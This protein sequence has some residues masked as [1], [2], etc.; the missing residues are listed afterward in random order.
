MTATLPEGNTAQGVFV[1]GLGRNRHPRMPPRLGGERMSRVPPGGQ[2]PRPPVWEGEGKTHNFFPHKV[3]PIQIA[4]AHGLVLGDVSLVKD[5]RIPRLWRAQVSTTHPALERAFVEGFLP[6][7]IDGR[8][9]K[10]PV[11][12]GATPYKWNIYAWISAEIAE[13]LAVKGPRATLLYAESKDLLAA[14]TAGLFDSDGGLSLAIVRRK[15]MNYR[16][17]FEPR[18]AIYNADK[19]LLEA[20]RRSWLKYGIRL[21]LGKDR[22]P[23]L[24]RPWKGKLVV[25]ELATASYPMIVR[26]LL[27]ILPYMKHWEKITKAKITIKHIVSTIPW[28]PQPIASLR[29][30]IDSLIRLQVHEYIKQAEQAYKDKKAYIITRNGVIEKKVKKPKRKEDPSPSLYLIL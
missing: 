18:V 8:I 4:Y 11:R 3:H 26:F 14:F 20:L 5:R 1:G 24:K 9:R 27:T 2:S 16:P 12:G 13:I 17:R 22:S 30:K 25:Y 15:R 7:S 10:Y 23:Q 6:L 19:E 29:D 21:R 28:K